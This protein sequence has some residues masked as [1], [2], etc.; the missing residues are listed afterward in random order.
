M[1]LLTTVGKAI[2]KNAAKVFGKIVTSKAIPE[3]ELIA[4]AVKQ[5]EIT[6]KALPAATSQFR[7]LAGTAGKNLLLTA[8]RNPGKTL[9]A[10]AT[11]PGL[12]NYLYKNPNTI[13]KAGTAYTDLA[14][15][16]IDISNN[17][18][19]TFGILGKYAKE[20]PVASSVILIGSSYLAAKNLPFGAG[21]VVGEALDK[22]KT[23][24]NDNVPTGG[25]DPSDKKDSEIIQTKD[26]E[27]IID[28]DKGSGALIPDSPKTKTLTTTRKRKKR[29]ENLNNPLRVTN[30]IQILNLAQ[31]R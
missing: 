19:D 10:G 13:I 12:A 8:A 26:D 14:K 20:H 30:K 22:D 28:T 2:S 17:P 7:E 29:P 23:Q 25:A 1:G 3:T 15:T 11:V 31:A 18:K 21:L 16:G 6:Q 5:L 4:P 27:K 24:E 9:I